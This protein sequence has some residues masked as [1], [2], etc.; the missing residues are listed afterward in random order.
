MIRGASRWQ[1]FILALVAALLV[2]PAAA[3][4]TPTFL[5]AINISDPGQDG[6]EP[7]V[8]VDASGNVTAVW[9]RSDGT[10]FRIQSATRTPTGSWS[11]PQTIS[12]PGQ[13]A[14][15]PQIALDSSG[16][17]VAVW[18]RS[19]GTN[20]R[21]QAA[22]KPAGGSFQAA[23]TVSA[24]G[25]DASAPTVSLDNS[26]QALVAW[27][28]TDGTNLRVQAAIRS[29]GMGGLFGAISTLSASGQDA[30]EPKV[31]AGPNVDANGV[32]VWTRSDG[33]N[34][35]VQSSRRRDVTGFPRPKGATPTR[36]SLVDA[37]NQCPT[38]N[39]THGAP[40]VF[41][42]C[43]PPV[44]SS[45][46]L[47][48]GTTDAN[49]AAANFVGSVRYIV[50]NGDPT[51]EANEADLKLVVSLTDIRNNPSLTDYVGKVLVTSDVQITDQQNAPEQPEPG[52]VQTFKFEFPT[53]CVST[54]STTVGSNCN[55]N[56]T[57]NALIPGSVVES[58]R[59]VWEL[60]QVSVKD[61]GPNATGYEN[62]PPTCGDGD[63]TTFLREGVF[64]P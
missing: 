57:A 6:F 3:Q 11:V 60:G 5:S 25:F 54:V 56:T 34:L 44:Q 38:G 63:E 16:N 2:I 42:S 26:G 35:R 32:V 53:S 33:T 17:A 39:R 64:V 29:P 14:S 7:E 55:A 9:T 8:A 48:I 59:S 45:S 28:R 61:A 1:L 15:G 30:F 24:S 20:L 58:K 52:T 50:L 21:I 31:A 40:L 46:V 10:N 43:A 37:F 27:Q 23:V 49:G 13:G 4:A 41:P 36:V 22:Y 19:D 18:T 12:D 47:T 62:C 51:T